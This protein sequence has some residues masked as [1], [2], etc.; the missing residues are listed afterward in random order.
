MRAFESRATVT[1][2]VAPGGDPADG[3]AFARRV[4]RAVDD[5]AATARALV[6]AGHRVGLR[7]PSGAV[8][9]DEGPPQLERLLSHIAVLPIPDEPLGGELARLRAHLGGRDVGVA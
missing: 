8:D 7:S 4:D 1:I 9:P 3:L 5:A 6:G 2:V